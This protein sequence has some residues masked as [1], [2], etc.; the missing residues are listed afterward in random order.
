VCTFILALACAPPAFAVNRSGQQ[1]FGTASPAPA[2]IPSRTTGVPELKE[3]A[4]T[5]TYLDWSLTLGENGDT[6]RNG[7]SPHGGY[8]TATVKCV[9]CHSVHY[10]APVA[11]PGDP[12]GDYTVASGNN[13]ADALL[14]IRALNACIYCH[15]TAG[16]AVGTGPVYDGDPSTPGHD[17]G[18]NCDMCHSSVHGDPTDVSVASLDGYLLKMIPHDAVGPLR[19]PSETMLDAIVVLD[20]DAENQ[21]F[22]RGALLGATIQAYALDNDPVLRERAV[23]IFCAQCHDGSYALVAPGGSANV[24]GS[25]DAMYSGHRIAATASNAWNAGGSVSSGSVRDR[26]VAWAPATNCKSCHDAKGI[27]GQDAFPHGWGGTKMWLMSASAAG[28]ALTSLPLDDGSGGD[29]GDNA[30]QL[31]DGVCLKCHVS[32]TRLAGVGIDF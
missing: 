3:G 11:D 12:T 2:M 31:S 30:L 29:G 18:D 9:V 21:G 20:R 14:R 22:R 6:A 16:G 5:Y 7:N 26:P 1:R 24:S 4:G 25:P 27:F 17:T 15:A 10:A 8:T 28:A 19:A 32:G 23:G 13:Q